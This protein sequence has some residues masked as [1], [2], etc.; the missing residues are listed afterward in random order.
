[1]TEY[2]LIVIGVSLALAVPAAAWLTWRAQVHPRRPLW[3][4]P[5][6]PAP[7][8]ATIQPARPRRRIVYPFEA[9]LRAIPDAEVRAPLAGHGHGVIVATNDRAFI[10]TVRAVMRAVPDVDVYLIGGIAPPDPQ[11]DP[12]GIGRYLWGECWRDGVL[13]GPEQRV[14]YHVSTLRHSQ[15]HYWL[16]RPASG[17]EL[18]AQTADWLAATT[19][20]A[21]TRPSARYVRPGG[22][23]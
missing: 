2:F 16:I 9:A 17:G 8:P 15:A 21:L 22:Q 6:A 19:P 3:L 12:Q 13:L 11:F 5:D 7:A 20:T 23:L 10:A 14:R 18:A 1:M 4:E